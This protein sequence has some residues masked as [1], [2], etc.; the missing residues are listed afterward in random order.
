M[1]QSVGKTRLAVGAVVAGV[2]LGCGSSSQQGFGPVD[3]GTDGR[4]ATVSHDSGKP[5]REGGDS[6]APIKLGGGDASNHC[7]PS[8][9]KELNAN[10][11]AV[12]DKKC[13]GVV[14]CGS[15]P[16]G[17]TCGGGG[18]DN[19]CGQSGTAGEA[20]AK[21]TCASQKISCGPASDGCGGTLSC[22][23]CTSPQICGGAKPG[24][25][26]CTGTCAQ[27]PL[28]EAGTTTLTGK[29]YDPAGIN[30]LYNVLVY[31][32]NNPSDPGLQPFA[33]GITCDI[34]GVTAAG[35]PLVT[36][37]TAPDG[38]FTLSGVPVGSAIP[39][40]IQLGRWRR[41]FTV[42]I[43][44]PCGANS[45]ADK[46]LEMPSSHGV[47]DMPR[48]AIVTGAL[49]PVECVLLK[50]GIDK[51]E[52]TDPGGGGYIQLYTAS[53][54]DSPDPGITGAG[55]KISSTT[56]TQAALFATADG[57]T[58]LIN[59]YDMTIFECE[60]YAE[61]ESQAELTALATYAGAGGRV[62]AS[63]Y[64]YAW[65]HPQSQN[66]ATS[67]PLSAAATWAA[68]DVQGLSETSI[69]DQPPDNPIGADFQQW[70]QD[71]GVS[72]VGSGTVSIDPAFANWKAVI[73]PTQQWLHYTSGTSEVP[74]HFVFNTPIE[75]GAGAA[76]GGGADGGST[77]QCGRVTYSDWHTQTTLNS[78]GWTFP[79]SCPS[80]ALTSQEAILE[81]MFFDLS[82]CVQPY[83]PI[84]TPRTCAQQGIQC[85]PAGDG[86]GN[87]IQCPPCEA[88][89][90]GGG[91]AGKCGTSTHCTPETCA[92]QNIQCGPAGDGCGKVLQCGSCASGQVCG[93]NSPGQ[94]GT[95][96]K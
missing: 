75:P 86:C 36:T 57:G 62:F 79:G 94:C 70:L 74:V 45:V 21:Q 39:L 13:G 96:S 22:G 67:S 89:T 53:D 88:G 84:C 48:I 91:G 55:A 8:T 56:P 73:P 82:A 93:I 15:C 2:S 72:T 92:S 35:D 69:I 77:L 44:T 58:P 1:G 63:H 28:C 25:C 83:K 29:V 80:S 3:G 64:Q 49:D 24:E 47:G 68:A 66:A 9:C 30:G 20:C 41:Q 34:C 87:L 43:A 59:N 50:I 12:T 11:G 65:L 32:P 23:N 61:K 10:C 81:F 46:T 52:F 60:G 90:C 71:V 17:E 51:S 76:D 40:V 7:V 31:V 6:S 38:T 27:V 78:T 26:G 18:V 14:Q 33:P 54:P 16:G 4:D 95:I 37:M 19:Q 85:G 5:S 42:N